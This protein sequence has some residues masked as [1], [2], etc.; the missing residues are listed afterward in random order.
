MHDRSRNVAMLDQPS[1]ILKSSAVAANKTTYS[2]G[3]RARDGE[4]GTARLEAMCRIRA[5]RTSM[6]RHGGIDRKWLRNLQL[7]RFK[8]NTS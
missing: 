1:E 2:L 5:G 6:N 3:Q 8:I 4:F 7:D